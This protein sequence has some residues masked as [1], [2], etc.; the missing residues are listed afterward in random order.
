MTK[1]VLRDFPDHL[2]TERLLI[3]APRP[4][5]GAVVN[6][7]ARESIHE[8]RDWMPWAQEIPTLEET[9]YFVRQ[10]AAG[11]LTQENLPMLLFRRAD[12]VFLG[13]S[14]FHALDWTVPKA[15]IGY[16]LR[17]R[18]T[19]QGYMTEAVIG[20]TQF[21]FDRME[22]VRLEI[23]CDARNTRSAAVA[24]RAGY[25]LDARFRHHMRA[26]DGSL[27]DTLVYARL[28]EQPDAAR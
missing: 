17:T 18:A 7:A 2:A 21:A 22:M 27:R 13:G 1:P 4:G 19:G 28:N 24:E 3:R 10:A 9:E 11:W 14:G 15:E 12:G 16:W 5:D 25:S 23:R 20:L 8:L 6:E 26:P